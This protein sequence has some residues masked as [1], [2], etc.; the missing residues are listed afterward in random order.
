MT[1][2]RPGA[3]GCARGL[4]PVDAHAL[5]YVAA[6]EPWRRADLVVAGTPMVPLGD[7]ELACAPGPIGRLEGLRNGPRVR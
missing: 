5:P 4:G 7:D 3:G 1:D 2:A 6:E